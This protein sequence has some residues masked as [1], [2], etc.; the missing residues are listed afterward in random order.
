MKISQTLMRKNIPYEYVSY[1]D[2]GYLLR[3]TEKFD[4]KL[5]MSLLCHSIML[6]FS[7]SYQ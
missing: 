2:D 3:Q 4:L 5:P 6:A 1:F 7:F